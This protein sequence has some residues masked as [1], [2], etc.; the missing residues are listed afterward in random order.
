M[1]KYECEKK[2]KSA[3]QEEIDAKDAELRK[4]RAELEEAKAQP[5]DLH[6]LPPSSQQQVDEVE[7]ELEQLRQSFRVAADEDDTSTE[8]ADWND[9]PRSSGPGS[10]G[11]D[12][13]IIH[14]DE[15]T[16]SQ[17]LVGRQPSFTDRAIASDAHTMGLELSAAREAKSNLLGSFRDQSTNTGFDFDFA[18]TPVRQQQ[19]VLSTASTFRIPETPP[20][21]H[22]ELSKQLKEA[23]NRAEEAEVALT[24]LDIEITSLGFGNAESD[25]TMAMVTAIANHFKQARLELERLVPGETAVGF[26][27][28]TVL[29]E[30]LK[31]I[32]LLSERLRGKE[33]ELKNA[34]D[35]HRNLKNNFEKA[36]IAAEKANDRMKRLEASVN[37]NAEEMLHIRMRSQQLEQDVAE[38]EKDVASLSVA[39]NKYRAD[40]SRLET[41][42]TEMQQDYD[43]SKASAQS[44]QSK[45]TELEARVSSETTGRRAAEISAV[46]RLARINELETALAT[47][48]RHAA[49]LESRLNSLQEGSASF[50]ELE[51]TAHKEEIA[52]LNGRI[53]SLATALTSANAEVDK[54]KITKQKLEER[55]RSEVEQGAKAVE[56]LQEQLIRTVM[57]GNEAR[58]RYVNGAK[59]RIA[60]WQLDDERES[61]SS[62]GGEEMSDARTPSSVRFSEW[63]EVETI[64]NRYEQ[65]V[66]L[67]AAMHNEDMSIE[68]GAESGSESVPGSVEIERGRGRYKKTPRLVSYDKARRSSQITAATSKKGRR[69]YDSGI[70]MSSDNEFEIFDEEQQGGRGA[71][72]NGMITPEASSEGDAEMALEEGLVA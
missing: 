58:K 39:L 52:N 14:E 23:T 53:S 65:E 43:Q 37:N 67:P 50:S 28:C 19:H 42:I 64:E 35:M 11:G 33:N 48:K 17:P 47:S 9:V 71:V 26:D 16:D 3:L 21:F 1:N 2:T 30:I 57:K 24:A 22:F 36:I 56:T 5:Q 66:E 60:N 49:D 8:I 69:R 46:Q 62:E 20:N 25:D 40:V 13:I 10:E 31:K 7:A 54:L 6:M 61:L 51:R 32:K 18:D 4:L 72:V 68:D 70:G 27:N 15:D 44:S 12:T 63:A 34:K 55:V 29:P 59:V 41:L 38:K 45:I